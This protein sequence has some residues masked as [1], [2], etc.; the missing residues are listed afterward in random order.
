M[1]RIGALAR[2]CGLSRSTLLYYDRIGLL[3]PGGRSE[4]GYRLYTPADRQRLQSI[5]SYRAAG[6]AL[7]EIGRLL[8]QPEEPDGALLQQRLQAIGEQIRALQLQQKLLAGML[9]SIHGGEVP[10]A[11]DKATWVAMLRAA[12]MDDAGMERWHQ[13]FEARAPE[14]HQ[15]FLERLGISAAE[16]RRIRAWSAEPD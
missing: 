16:I 15:E 4:A 14:A 5:C 6:L 3:R 1:L 11:V 8:D 12:G 7:D 2:E 13:A 10:Q 9:R